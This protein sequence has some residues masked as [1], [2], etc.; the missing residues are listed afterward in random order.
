M[1]SSVACP[2]R[3]IAQTM[4]RRHA[5]AGALFFG[6][7][8]AIVVANFFRAAAQFSHSADPGWLASVRGG[9]V[10]ILRVAEDGPARGV[11]RA[12]DRV[13][14]LGGY[15][16]PESLR[17]MQRFTNMRPGTPYTIEVERDGSL[18]RAVLSTRAFGDAW[19]A[20]VR[21][22]S[23]LLPPCFLLPAAWV[24]FMRPGDRRAQL[25]A[26]T[27]ACFACTS[28]MG[29]ET[30]W[31][32]GV[33]RWTFGLALAG[34]VLGS[35]FWPTLLHFFLVFPEPSPLARRFPRLVRLLYLPQLL[36]VLPASLYVS[37]LVV[38]DPERVIRLSAH[39]LVPVLRYIILGY[40]L[41]ALAVLVLN[42]AKED[43]PGARRKLRVVVAGTLAAVLPTLGVLALLRVKGPELDV[44][45]MRVLIATVAACWALLPLSFVY[46]ILRHQVIPVGTLLRRGARYLLVSK[47]FLVVQTAAAFSLLLFL[48][49][50][51]RAEALERFTPGGGVLVAIPL[52]AL[53]FGLLA[54]ANRR[55]L[56]RIDRRF[57]REA[58]DA[59]RLLSELGEALRKAPSAAAAAR[60]AA[61][62]VTEALHPEWLSLHL[63]DEAGGAYP[64]LLAVP[65][66][67]VP[68]AQA[69]AAVAAS[70][71]ERKAAHEDQGSGTL[72]VPV[73]ASGEL[74]GFLA[75]GPRK[76]DL[77]YS[78]EDTGLLSAVA[79]QLALSLENAALIRTLA[80]EER[81]R[82]ELYVASEVQQRLFPEPR[83][84]IEGLE[85]AGV[86]HP[87][88]GVGGDYYDFLALGERQVGVA[89][90]DVAGKGISAALLMSV[91]QA[92][93]RSQARAAGVPL[94]ELVASMNRLLYRS[95]ARNRF[96][97]FFYA[98]FDADSRRLTYVNAGHNPPLLIRG[99]RSAAARAVPRR[100]ALA[101]AA[102]ALEEPGREL[103]RLHT[104]GLVIGALPES[105]Y[106]AESLVLAE[107]DL[108]IAYTDGVTEAFDPDGEEFGE[109]RLARAALEHAERPA[110][111]IVAGL[112][113][114]VRAWSAGTP[115]H[116]DLTLVVA[117]VR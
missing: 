52:S 9:E 58:Y 12:G 111:E 76:G 7:V 14:A 20:Q 47:G 18:V 6:L 107:G 43:R 73:A 51:S 65:E 48:L 40:L 90:A 34:P 36:L 44:D 110:A 30:L 15:P 86:C 54:L 115:Q 28:L 78:R 62:R 55:L 74:L 113:E 61:E 66:E 3:M 93:L 8:G 83:F 116:D 79:L 105:S 99:R 95:T 102:L 31:L 91:V 87:A 33:P 68:G 42:Y 10:V 39:P 114:T 82:Q 50:G 72:Y 63:R 2:V 24:F 94:T 84:E 96:A 112:V 103:L 25:L 92:S 17:V 35:F 21:V 104:G 49:S 77:P 57:F 88:K 38:V 101:A 26:L 70:L 23:L 117:R 67:R 53:A 109:A 22:L 37:A 100:G 80:Q 4:S 11:L 16:R 19:T 5:L 89:V 45:A 97:S 81:L 71:R 56:P 41:A 75:L 29:G 13:V 46:A 85:L 60:L 59:Q 98:Q 27:F 64:A 106:R 69:S 32:E 1:P 108:L